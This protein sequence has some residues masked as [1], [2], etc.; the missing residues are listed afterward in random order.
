VQQWDV[1][2]RIHYVRKISMTKKTDRTNAV[3]KGVIIQ[4][5]IPKVP[6]EMKVLRDVK[7]TRGSEPT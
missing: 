2:Y 1:L 7:T 3:K 6:K 5:D 4:T